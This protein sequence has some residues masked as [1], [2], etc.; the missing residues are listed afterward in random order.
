[1]GIIET[2]L[3]GP[4]AEMAAYQPRATRTLTGNGE[5]EQVVGSVVVPTFFQ[6]MAV[7]P[8]R[9][10]TLVMDDLTGD[11]QVVVLSDGAWRRRFGEDPSIVGKTIILNG[12]GHEVVGVHNG[13]V[14]NTG[15]L[16]AA[17]LVTVLHGRAG[18]DAA[19]GRVGLGQRVAE[20]VGPDG[21]EAEDY[22]LVLGSE[23]FIPGFEGQQ[24]AVPFTGGNRSE[25][26]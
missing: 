4:F 17:H 21:G 12:T 2:Y 10:R 19:V 1:M 15:A 7:N 16:G 22:P 18:P 24:P 11:R 14:T 23:S 20:A 3:I 9:G 6:V 5:P 25:G 8:A 13:I 26:L